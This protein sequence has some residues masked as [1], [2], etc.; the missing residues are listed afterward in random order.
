MKNKRVVLSFQ[1]KDKQFTIIRQ[2][3]N[4]C[5]QSSLGLSTLLDHTRHMGSHMTSHVGSHMTSHM[6]ILVRT[7]LD[8]NR[9]VVEK[10]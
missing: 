4:L 5:Q 2:R 3:L 7:I 1:S 9:V 10:C 8:G 6:G